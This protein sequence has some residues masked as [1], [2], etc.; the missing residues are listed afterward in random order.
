MEGAPGEFP[1]GDPDDPPPL[2]AEEGL[3]RDIASQ[4]LE[5]LEGRA[6]PLAGPGCRNR[7]TGLVEKCQCQVLVD[8]RLHR[9]GRVPDGYARRRNPMQGIHPED[10]LL[11]APRRHHPHQHAVDLGQRNAPGLNLL[12]SPSQ[13]GRHLRERHGLER[14]DRELLGRATQVRNMPARTR[15]QGDESGHSLCSSHERAQ[16]IDASEPVLPSLARRLSL[17]S[18]S[19]VDQKSYYLWARV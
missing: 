12:L 10:D 18:L 8:G 17:R 15:N 4:R 13:P 9:A 19:L 3:D 1:V 2:R 5:G 6:C 7:Q 14:N 16:L 11:Q